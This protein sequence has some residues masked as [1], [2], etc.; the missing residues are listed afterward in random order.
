MSTLHQI[1]TR[2]LYLLSDVRI[3]RSTIRTVPHPVKAV[4]RILIKCIGHNVEETSP[5]HTVTSNCSSERYG[6]LNTESLFSRRVSSLAGNNSVTARQSQE[7]GWRHRK[8]SGP[9]V[10]DLACHRDPVAVRH[11]AIQPV[12]AVGR[13]CIGPSLPPPRAPHH[14]EGLRIR[15]RRRIPIKLFTGKRVV[16]SL[17]LY[18]GL[19]LTLPANDKA[20]FMAEFWSSPLYVIGLNV[21]LWYAAIGLLIIAVRWI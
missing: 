2:Y 15:I 8:S 5:F 14:A 9:E 12:A 18:F 4:P 20:A 21:L 16:A 6:L 19:L 11:P 7:T 1:S 13:H 10:T 3:E 17:L